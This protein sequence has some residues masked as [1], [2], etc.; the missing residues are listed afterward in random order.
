MLCQFGCGNEAK[1]EPKKGLKK[2]CCSDDWRKCPANRT[3]KGLNVEEKEKIMMNID[4]LSELDGSSIDVNNLFRTR[5]IMVSCE[6]CGF[7]R[8]VRIVDF[9]YC[10]TSFCN[11]CSK[12][13]DRNV[14]KRDDVR[15]KL[16]RKGIKDTSYA[17][18]EWRKKFSENRKGS[19][20]PNY[21]HILSPES[22]KLKR[23]VAI[24]NIEKRI[25]NG[26]QISPGYNPLACKLIEEYGK[27]HGYNFQHAE[28]G[29]EYRIRELGYWV[30]GYDKE[31][32]VVIEIDEKF[33]FDIYGNLKERDKIRQK[34]ITD[35][36]K[37]KFIRIRI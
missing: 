18:T 25:S 5:R 14:S 36:L 15:E 4:I 7:T 28:N 27:E 30:D 24:R 21:G 22:R 29:G 16:S 11:S 13:G 23:L 10:K 19:K 20:N 35:F 2:W 6:E 9:L 17:T 12:L 32:N 3:Y 33:H 26:Y 34:E 1:F 8:D 31:K 37:C